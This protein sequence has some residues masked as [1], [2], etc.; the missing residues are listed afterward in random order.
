M[1]KFLCYVVNMEKDVQKLKQVSEQFPFYPDIDFR[2]WKACEGKRLTEEQK[3]ELISPTFYTRYGSKATLP[4]VGCSLSHVQ[5]YQNIVE[6]QLPYAMIIEDDAI[7]AKSLKMESFIPLLSR[8][9]PT[10]ILLTPDFRYKKSDKYLQIGESSVY[11]LDNGLMTSGY[12]INNAAA[13]LLSDNLMPIKYLADAWADFV[14]MGLHLYGVTP[15]LVSFPDELGEIGLSQR[16]QYNHS[17]LSVRRFLGY[18]HWKMYNWYLWI[19][20]YRRAS[21]LWR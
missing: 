2:I 19:K 13:K 8:E 4:A 6:Q 10:A 15:H 17:H 11:C 9:V 14:N 20:G 12:L 16:Q 7:L 18:A 5:I 3:K 1:N 21:K